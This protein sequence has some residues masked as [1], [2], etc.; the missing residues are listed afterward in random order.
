[1]AVYT[2]RSTTMVGSIIRAIGAVIA[3]ILILH[4]LFVLLGAN[5]AN[6]FV[7]FI[8]DWA[9]TLALWFK[10]LFTTGNAE[11]DLILNYGLAVVF[12]VVVF[13]V[14]ARLIEHAG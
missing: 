10:D 12:W 3:V 13:G 7:R 8:A 2:R 5:A 4:V 9:G 1:M 6:S 11:V 14:I